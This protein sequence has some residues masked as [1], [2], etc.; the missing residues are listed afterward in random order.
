MTQWA[1][2]TNSKFVL[3][4]VKGYKIPFNHKPNQKKPP[5]TKT[6]SIYEVN[7]INAE[8]QQL[9]SKGAIR[10]C[11]HKKGEFL[12]TFFLRKKPNESFRF[13]LN[14]KNLNKYISA[15]HFK[16]ED[17]RVVQ[18][19][20]YKNCYMATLDLTDAYFLIPIAESHKKYLRFSFNNT[21]YEFSCLCFGLNIAPYLFTKIIKPVVQKLRSKNIL[22]VMYLDDLLIIGETFNECLK[23][24]NY[25]K[26]LL[27]S[28]GFIINL[29]KSRTK[30]SQECKYLG[31]IFNSEEMSISL[32]MVKKQ[33]IVNKLNKI[34]VKHSCKIREFASTIGTLIS[35]CP[36]IPY[37]WLHTKTFE[38]EKY[39]ALKRG[40][41]DYSNYMPLHN[42]LQPEI[43]WWINNFKNDYNKHYFKNDGYKIE[44][45]TDA[46]TTGWGAFSNGER[47]HGFW[48]LSQINY[49]INVLELVAAFYGLKCFAKEYSNCRILLRLDSTTAVAY[50]NRMGGIKF[51]QLNLITSQ[52]WNWCEQRKIIIFASYINTKDNLEADG[53]SRS[54]AKD[55]EFS[56]NQKVFKKITQKLGTPNIDLFASKSNSKCKKYISWHRDP[57]S[58][59]VDAFTI[60]WTNLF[61][62]AFPPFCLVPR[63]LN[64]IITDKATGLIVVPHWPSQPWYPLFKKLLVSKML[65]FKPSN[66]L[67]LS[68]FREPHPMS[69]TLT[70]AAGKL[71]GE[72]FN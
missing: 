5:P 24:V 27:K 6:N 30:P 3:N 72:L 15:P 12:S 16:L 63:V 31:F 43:D 40:G 20:L 51:K 36:A 52:I 71:C 10:R 26:D 49:H 28:L 50:I 45:F 18:N 34:K 33:N 14:L 44:I 32:P 48:T 46:S 39:L 7:A 62:Y 70:L 17:Y 53:E 25:A 37:G 42:C 58:F 61:F 11:K 57:D 8:L 69:S 19:L 9:L 67:L 2:L 60:S 65:F 13:I 35:A 66:I 29:E 56:L 38:R 23:N 1:D 54:I 21:L 59:A 4:A 68:P 22:S 55:T 41:G 64:K 47:T